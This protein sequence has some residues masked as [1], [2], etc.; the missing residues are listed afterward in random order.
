MAAKQTYDVIFLDVQ[1]PGID[2]FE[3]CTKNHEKALNRETPVVFVTVQ[4]DFDAR[5]KATLCGG[6]DLIAKPF[7]VLEITVKA[8]TLALGARLENRGTTLESA[9][10]PPKPALLRRPASSVIAP[11]MARLPDRGLL[12]PEIREGKTERTA[13]PPAQGLTGM[14]GW[15]ERDSAVPLLTGANRLNLGRALDQ[16]S[17]QRDAPARVEVGRNDATDFYY[18]LAPARLKELRSQL[19]TAR[20]ATDTPVRQDRLG[21]LSAAVHS[22]AALTQRAALNSTHRLCSALE[23]L[24]R[25]LHQRADYCTPSALGAAA[26]ALDLLEELCRSRT[27]PDLAAP[28]IRILVVDDDVIARRA[29]GMAVQVSFGRPESAANGQAA[30]DLAGQKPFDVIFLDV[31][32]PGMDGFT[33]CAKIHETAVNRQTP[34]VFVTGHSD[35][36]SRSQAALSGGCGFIP[37]PALTSEI[38]VTALTYTLRG[39]LSQLPPAR[40]PAAATL[41]PPASLK[42]KSLECPDVTEEN[43]GGKRDETPLWLA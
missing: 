33:T 20:Q 15:T 38:T 40:A 17:G 5:A 14:D 32:M 21:E 18:A 8:L 13:R 26:A 34:V 3:V 25:K 29:L 24:L 41:P 4:S 19:H 36:G 37:K 11:P 1:M 27:E 43:S 9:D 31:C 35:L 28:P 7:L 12:V 42:K 16:D 22:M 23:G 10:Q 6:N 2:G 30:L 39:R